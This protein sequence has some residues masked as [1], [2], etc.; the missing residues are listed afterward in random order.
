MCHEQ[1]ISFLAKSHRLVTKKFGKFWIFFLSRKFNKQCKNF[2]KIAKLLKPLN[3]FFI[4]T[5][6]MNQGFV[7]YVVF[8][9]KAQFHTWDIELHS[10]IHWPEW[11]STPSMGWPLWHTCGW[12]PTELISGF[13]LITHTIRSRSYIW[14]GRL[15]NRQLLGN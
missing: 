6:V 12:T 11:T 2:G 15:K 3:W 5:L 7:I 8:F 14:V 10:F 1:W 13:T 4:K 9:Y